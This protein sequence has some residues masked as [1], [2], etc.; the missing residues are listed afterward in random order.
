MTTAI[1]CRWCG[2]AITRPDEW[3]DHVGCTR[4]P[5]PDAE[6]FGL[7]PDAMQPQAWA[8]DTPRHR[9]PHDLPLAPRTHAT[10]GR[11]R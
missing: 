2:Q 5:A 4:L 10:T 3:F 7:R 9:V 1:T 11:R 8:V 6:R